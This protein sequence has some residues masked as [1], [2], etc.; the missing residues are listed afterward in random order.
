VVFVVGMTVLLFGVALIV[1][2]GPA[3]VVIPAGLAILSLEFTWARRWMKRARAVIKSG[4]TKLFG[5]GNTEGQ[6]GE[7]S[8]PGW[9][10]QGASG[11]AG[12]GDENRSELDSGMG[13]FKTPESDE[14][15]KKKDHSGK[16]QPGAP[17]GGS[18]NNPQAEQDGKKQV[19]AHCSQ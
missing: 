13:G 6:V 9:Q 7:G 16:E 18:H 17:F 19:H 11:L 15:E 1:L 2:P 5:R 14:G 3:I 10:Q 8:P 4:E 12:G